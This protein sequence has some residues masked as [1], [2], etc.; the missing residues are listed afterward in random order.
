M[1]I[2]CSLLH[3]PNPRSHPT[4]HLQLLFVA[5]NRKKIMRGENQISVTGMRLGYLYFHMKFQ[6][7]TSCQLN[8]MMEE[9]TS[10]IPVPWAMEGSLHSI[11]SK[12]TIRVAESVSS[13]FFSILESSHQWDVHKLEGVQTRATKMMK[14]LWRVD[15]W[16]QI[17]RTKYV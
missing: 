11:S 15:L 13:H 10:R 12:F 3:F 6:S 9:P 5:E 1:K 16:G 14:G 8:I 2:L 7:A 17:K 4:P